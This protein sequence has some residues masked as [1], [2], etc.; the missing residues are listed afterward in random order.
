VKRRHAR[1]GVSSQDDIETYAGVL[2]YQTGALKT[3]NLFI[4]QNRRPQLNKKVKVKRQTKEAKSKK[5]K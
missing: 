5:Q 1:S 4:V 2:L 3:R